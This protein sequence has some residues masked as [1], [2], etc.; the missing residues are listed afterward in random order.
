MVVVAAEV[1]FS[2]LGPVRAWREGRELDL[3]SPQQCGVLGLLLLGGGRPVAVETLVDQLWGE[4]AP[5]SARETVRTYLSRL[6]RALPGPEGGSLIESGRGGYALPV[7]PEALDLAVFEDR[8]ARAR[9]SR[10]EGDTAPAAGLLREA[11]ALWRGPALAG[12]RGRFVAHERT[13]LDQ[14]R[15]V[16]LEERL[17]LDLDLGRHGEVLA[18]LASLVIGY[19]LQER[20]RELQMLAL[21]RCARQADALEVYR[22][23]RS[24]LDRELGIEPGPDL[25]ALHERMLRADP[26]LDLPAAGRAPTI[27]PSGQRAAVR[28]GAGQVGT[29]L[30]ST[31]SASTAPATTALVS[32]ALV[33]TAPATTGPVST[34]LVST[35]PAGTGLGGTGLARRPAGEPDYPPTPA[36][37]AWPSSRTESAPSSASYISTTAPPSTAPAGPPP[38]NSGPNSAPGAGRG[39]LADRLQAVRERGFVGRAAERALFGSALA[40]WPSAFVALFLH[41]PGGVGKS[42]LLRRLA[43]DA[44]TA[45]R[46][47]VRVDG[48]LVASS[49]AAFTAAAG[50]TVV[51]SDLVLLIDN[52]EHC[53]ALES[54]L[55][56]DFL[57]QLSEDVLV[58]IAGRNPP[59]PSWRTD[60]SWAGALRVEQLRDL[61]PS[62]A[63]ALLLVRGVAPELHESLLQFAG[64]HP[65]ALTLA[66]E[67]AAQAGATTPTVLAPTRD[68][69]ETMLAEL[70]GTVPSPKHRLALQ[71]CAHAY[72]TTEDLLRAV[73]PG[74]MTDPDARALFSWLRGLSFIETGSD[75]IY[76]HDVVRD[77]LEM[78]LRWRDAAG[79]EEIHRRVR[80]YVLGELIARKITGIDAIWIA[81]SLRRHNIAVPMAILARLDSLVDERP[82]RPGDRADILAMAA[83]VEGVETARTVSFWLDRQPSAFVVF[84]HRGLGQLIGFATRLVLDRPR[85]DEIAADPLVAAAWEQSLAAAAP[86]EGDH[87]AVAR[88]IV[89]PDARL[90][91]SA[92]VADPEPMTAVPAWPS[93]RRLAW[94]YLAVSDPEFWQP[95]MGYLDQIRIPA[96]P[97]VD[98]RPFGMFAHD[99]RSNGALVASAPARLGAPRPFRR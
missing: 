22:G 33:N 42:T 46:T 93:D 57:P 86:G 45:G 9:S 1:R 36:V 64:G 63:A 58:V 29:G 91:P 37:A 7:A 4:L 14:L 76:P 41:G 49:T 20:L 52:F 27:P 11:L 32:T 99:W 56:E 68:V 89:R 48:R 28:E 95:L 6:R 43:D 44:V 50:S 21:Y 94:S 18:E 97:L 80:N 38:A 51:T 13:R 92:P 5:T 53:Q 24:L 77:A 26:V 54:W 23:V 62:D 72:S 78:D 74:G 84:R 39:V 87:I 59:S 98:G 82:L 66:A 65:L 67:V 40:G 19:P 34:G 81:R 12:A 30:A 79:Y 85:A 47:V 61:A 73:L 83:E 70:V 69:I 2:V 17:A 31:A 55:R 88:Q 96:A 60:P 25:R 35:E 10:A 71:V 16:A 8:V 75:G 3:G 90:L 15:L